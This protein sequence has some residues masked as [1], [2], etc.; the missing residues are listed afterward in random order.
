MS[1]LLAVM[2][3]ASIVKGGSIYFPQIW[4]GDAAIQ[5]K[6]FEGEGRQ[7]KVADIEVPPPVEEEIRVFVD[8]IRNDTSPPIT[9]LG[10]SRRRRNCISRIPIC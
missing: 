1:P 6:P 2:V 5:I 7:I 8:A 10:R 3:A 4:G 9:G